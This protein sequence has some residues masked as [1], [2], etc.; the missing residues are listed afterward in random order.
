[1]S[2]RYVLAALALSTACTN[3][4]I[5]D[6][7]DFEYVTATSFKQ[8]ALD[9]CTAQPIASTLMVA[10]GTTAYV[11]APA[12]TEEVFVTAGSENG[13]GPIPPSTALVTFDSKE[14]VTN[15]SYDALEYDWV[16][17]TPNIGFVSLTNLAPI[18]VDFTVTFKV[19]Q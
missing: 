19:R 14:R 10:P 17:A 9:S 8:C 16:P 12:G 2:L 11:V 4:A 5:T 15:Q 18:Y 13:S 7:D 6:A 3:Q 1:M